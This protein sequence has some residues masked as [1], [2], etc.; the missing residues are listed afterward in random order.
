MPTVS[1]LLP[2]Y[3][4]ARY[5]TQTLESIYAQTY[6]DLEI[7]ASD[8]GSTD[9]TVL[10]LNEFAC[11][12]T[13]PFTI[14]HNPIRGIAS[15]WNNCLNYSKG[16]YIKFVFQD[17]V[18]A[19]NCLDKMV[20]MMERNPNM[21]LVFSP[22]NL[23]IESDEEVREFSNLMQQH[24]S[25]LHLGWSKLTAV[26]RGAELLNDGNLISAPLN[27]IG[28]PSVVL[29][30]KSVLDLVGNFDSELCQLLDLEMWW[31]ILAVS[32]VGFINEAL[33]SFRIHK[34]QASAK[35]RM[36]GDSLTDTRRFFDKVLA[37]NLLAYMHPTVR[38]EIA[39]IAKQEQS[40]PDDTPAPTKSRDTESLPLRNVMRSLLAFLSK[41]KKL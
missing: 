40:Q 14:V 13:I 10:L 18:I 8:D 20:A 3:N 17:D 7:I 22:R 32:D 34:N 25:Q 11:K 12:N 36:S 33:S 15:N 38:S 19:V 35:N 39:T 28:E 31:R 9:D 2:T 6:L 27:K 24:F 5:I 41:G 37:S 1:V 4:G 16:K 30:R 29:L 23:I 21:G 26:Q